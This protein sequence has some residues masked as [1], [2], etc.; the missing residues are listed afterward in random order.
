MA[1]AF[2]V[3]AP[4]SCAA[5]QAQAAEESEDTA[6]EH[7]CCDSKDDEAPAE[8]DDCECGECDG[9]CTTA[10]EDDP[11]AQTTNIEALIPERDASVDLD[12][13]SPRLQVLM[14]SWLAEQDVQPASDEPLAYGSSNSLPSGTT[15]TYLNLQVLRL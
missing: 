4:C 8:G 5:G 1:T 15:P 11:T 2:A 3:V 7:D 9:D 12:E 6:S 13:F 10:S 14:I